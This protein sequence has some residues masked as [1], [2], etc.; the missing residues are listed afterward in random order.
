MNKNVG[1][2]SLQKEYR[3]P[4]LEEHQNSYKERFELFLPNLLAAVVFHVH[5]ISMTHIRTDLLQLAAGKRQNLWLRCPRG[6]LHFFPFERHS[7]F[8]VVLVR[9]VRLVFLRIA[10]EDS[11][12]CVWL[13]GRN[14]I[15]S[16]SHLTACNL[17]KRL[18]AGHASKASSN[19]S[20]PIAI[21]AT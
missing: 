15:F 2:E 1:A 8:C 5:I 10:W 17:H 4:L 9:V 6:V 16:E 3:T 13:G 7:D 11:F 18:R 12:S 14:P 21:K 20:L 19:E